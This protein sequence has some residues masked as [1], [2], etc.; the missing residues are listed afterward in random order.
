[1]T[2]YKNY[3]RIISKKFF[4][5]KG[6]VVIIFALLLV[7]LLGM[8]VF[9]VDFGSLYQNKGSLQTV[10]DSAALAGA[11]ELPDY[12]DDAIGKALEYAASNNVN[13]TSEDTVEI[14]S[15]L[16]TITVILSNKEA[17]LY[18]AKI[19]GTSVANISA[20]AKAKVGRPI[21]MYNTVPWAI[22]IPEGTN[23]ESWLAGVVGEEKAIKAI[24]EDE[25]NGEEESYFIAWDDTSWQGQWN[26]RYEDRIK[27]GYSEA[28]KKN[29][30][31]IYIREINTGLMQKTVSAVED[32]IDVWDSFDYIVS[33]G[34]IK[35]LLRNDDQVVIIPVIYE[36]EVG[37]WARVR[38][39]APF[40]LID[41]ETS[42]TEPGQGHGHGHGHGGDHGS[43]AQ[44]PGIFIHQALVVNEGEI[45]DFNS[46][47]LGFK[48][49]RL[50]R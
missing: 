23:W 26:K 8:A 2:D 16:D 24:E 49:I 47:S 18:F 48:V 15:S 38:A 1:M 43:D 37:E 7:C 28:L 9:V 41:P 45:A 19:F 21:E 35:K 14:N 25:E 44:V 31:D 12:P 22:V 33:N 50:I 17:P 10:A 27:Y 13:I 36:T 30:D 42:S 6:Q 40:I 39:F 3:N 11:Q 5:Q 29:E 20:E 32:R 46:G 34:D 4:S